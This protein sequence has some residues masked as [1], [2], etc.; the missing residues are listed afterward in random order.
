MAGRTSLHM[1]LLIYSV[2]QVYLSAWVYHGG[3]SHFSMRILRSPSESMM[4]SQ[5]MRFG[6]FSSIIIPRL[7]LSSFVY[8]KH[9]EGQPSVFSTVPA[10]QANVLAQGS[11]TRTPS[12]KRRIL[13]WSINDYSMKTSN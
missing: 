6:S 5:G 10:K 7:S 3:A 11:V 13:P 1:C 9:K 4:P 8:S 2:E 12:M